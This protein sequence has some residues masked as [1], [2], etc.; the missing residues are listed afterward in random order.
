MACLDWVRASPIRKKLF[1][2]QA[3]ASEA[4]CVQ[5]TGAGERARP[6]HG[7]VHTH[8]GMIRAE[9]FRRAPLMPRASM[10]GKPHHRPRVSTAPRLAQTR[11]HT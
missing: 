3:L 1:F 4:P 6:R 7:R 10:R 8:S 9:R 2:E 11:R 5:H